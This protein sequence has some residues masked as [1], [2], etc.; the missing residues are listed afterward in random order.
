MELLQTQLSDSKQ[1]IDQL[2]SELSVCKQK[3]DQ[4]ES[5]LINLQERNETLEA[6]SLNVQVSALNNGLTQAHTYQ[7]IPPAHDM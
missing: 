7:A 5:Q 2:E 6:Q 3:V 1:S 4:L